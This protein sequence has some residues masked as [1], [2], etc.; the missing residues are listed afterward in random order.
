M[1]L[2]PSDQT[3]YQDTVTGLRTLR[4]WIADSPE[5]Q[6]SATGQL[7]LL[8]VLGVGS[9]TLKYGRDAGDT[10]LFQVARRVGQVQPRS[11]VLTRGNGNTFLYWLPNATEELAQDF[12][13]HLRQEI[14]GTP[15]TL[16]NADAVSPKLIF[17]S[18]TVEAG[19]R[20]QTAIQSLER[21]LVRQPE[22]SA[23]PTCISRA[24]SAHEELDRRL[25][26]MGLFGRDELVEQILASLQLPA[27]YPQTVLVAGL[28]NS[29]KTRLLNSIAKLLGA[30]RLPLAEVD[31]RPSDQAVP[32][33][34][35]AAVLYQFLS[36][37][38]PEMLAQRLGAVLQANPWLVGLFPTLGEAQ[39]APPPPQDGAVVRRVLEAILAELVRILPHVAVIHSLHLADDESLAAFAHLQGMPGHGLRIIAGI[40]QVD[41]ALPERIIR[42]Q[43]AQ[44]TQLTLEPLTLEQIGAYL[45][46]VVPEL[47]SPEMAERLFV[48]S[49]GLPLALELTLRAWAEDGA[50]DFRDGQWLF[51]PERI[52][53]SQEASLTDVD[54]ERLTKAALVGPMPLT[55][56]AQLWQA[57][58]E[59]VR[60]TVER[61]RALGY[62][63]PIDFNQPELVQFTDRDRANM[64][65]SVLAPETRTA[66]HAEIAQLL[67][68]LQAETKAYG[69]EL[70]YHYAQAGQDDRARQYAAQLQLMSQTLTPILVAPQASPMGGI[71]AWDIPP[72]IP[73]EPK[74]VTPIIEAALAVR[75]AGVQF[76]LY[77]PTSQ[78]AR[79]RVQE[80]MEAF[81][82][83]FLD[84]PSFVITFDGR[85]VAFDGQILMRRDLAIAVKDF[86][87]WMGDGNLRAIGISCCV[88]EYELARFLHA[89]A[90]YEPKDKHSTLLNKVILLNLTNIR[91]L[92]RSFQPD[93]PQ[94]N[95]L[96]GGGFA[97]GGP[98]TPGNSTADIAGLFASP[99]PPPP[100]SMRFDDESPA[101][102][103]RAMP[104]VPPVMSAAGIPSD[105]MPRDLGEDTVPTL[106]QPEG[107]DEHTL[108][109]LPGLVGNASPR[110]R[111]VM[112][113]NLARWM[114]EQTENTK[115][116]ITTS[117]DHLL[118]ERLA[119]EADLPALQ[120]TTAAVETR[121][122]LLMTRRDWGKMIALLE[123]LRARMNEE[124]LPEVQQQLTAVLS[125]VGAST[126]LG[127]LLSQAAEQPENLDS[128][129][130]VITLLDEF[131]LRPLIDTLK[132]ATV[133][134]ERSRLMQLLR[135]FG[136]GQQ[137]LLIEELRAPNPWY[138]YRNLLQV[139]AEVGN[140]EA[141]AAI[142]E[143]ITHPDPRVRAESVAAATMIA[144]EQTTV[145]LAQGL[146]D[147]DSN[148]RARAASLVSFCPQPLILDI[149]LRRLQARGSESD[150]M[151][152]TACFGLG[153]FQ[154]EEARDALL[155][156]LY[157]RL[158]SPY[159]KKS[160]E[161]RSAAVTALAQ[162]LPHPAV[163][164]AIKH[165]T[166]DRSAQ[167]RQTAQRVWQQYQV[168]KPQEA[169]T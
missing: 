90:T 136:G 153:Y 16:P 132:N 163:E 42:L 124:L 38:P 52:G 159:R 110:T 5:G 17:T 96:M 41:N 69:Q 61:G 160:D 30:Q 10:L 87:E 140:E 50:L 86:F 106:E 20:L 162:H 39:G 166:G 47:T 70:A 19:T 146:E 36:A 28:A 4:G 158:F 76:R 73:I 2:P 120:E 167:I 6:L 133:M 80:A 35:L 62:L 128:A 112:M 64:L 152:L 37:Y 82:R 131:A 63:K 91:V 103:S 143:K 81:S 127:A 34:L 130:R 169:A 92:T 147:S 135:E 56:L 11:S 77:P 15:I 117:I 32:C 21:E 66:I 78:M 24:V 101:T 99:P 88:R 14:L 142:S 95:M 102:P 116:K 94:M 71:E 164:A 144:K 60:D 65:L 79:A 134:Q 57:S 27:M 109:E 85:T 13:A 43:L 23:I 150:S 93:L 3:T 18:L 156:I 59:A 126:A 107:L 165:A 40:E 84:R 44:A 67:E 121:L 138:V 54:Q 83:L 45:R 22:F 155:Q 114:G 51:A 125:R 113:A 53:T 141:L 97:G 7:I 1:M 115:P 111:R 118:I 58:P 157:P 168:R 25:S 68:S 139:L 122:E 108:A 151:Q 104:Y 89:I 33:T 119:H 72:A 105:V 46:E 123:P 137:P 31:N 74:D 100:P 148:V 161:I 29:G 154:Q 12:I 98:S 48:E 8:D 75:L 55:V 26:A 149:L 49:H 145:Y 9:V 129:R